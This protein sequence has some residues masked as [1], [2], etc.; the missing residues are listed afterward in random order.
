MTL[1]LGM[2]TLA[3]GGAALAQTTPAQPA[4]ATPA[5]PTTPAA[6]AADP[7]TPVA[8]VG[9]ETLTLG[10]FDEYFR[11]LVGRT[12]NAQGVP[13]TDDVLPSFNQYRPQILTQFARQQAVLQLARTA[14]FKPDQAQLDKDLAEAKSGFTDDT[15]FQDALKSSGFGSLDTFSASLSDGAVYSAY[16]DSLK[17]KFKF[18]DAVVASFYQTNKAAFT[19]AAQ[20]CAK[21]ILVPTQAEAQDIV[22]KLSGGAAFADLAKAQSKDPGSAAQGGDLGCLNAGETVAAFDKAAFTGPVATPQIVQTEFGWHVL[23]VNSRTAA[24]VTPLTEVAPKI[25][26]QL[27]GDAAQKYVN[28]QIAKIK[29]A[30]MPEVVTVKADPA[31]AAPAAPTPAAP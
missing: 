6:P 27:A 17:G 19:H 21:H 31:S 24:G 4:P 9:S 2:G 12:V 30:T 13:L 18:G 7:S 16:L 14:G 11:Q 25:R 28:S 22:K 3:V 26:D 23:V 15:E 1:A 8:T 5:A 20:S 29:I 10:Q